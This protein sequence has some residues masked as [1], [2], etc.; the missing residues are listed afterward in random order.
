MSVRL[1]ADRLQERRQKI[2]NA[3]GEEM[4]L[5]AKRSLQQAEVM[6]DER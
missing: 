2:V 4:V 3:A 1:R 5:Q 6:N